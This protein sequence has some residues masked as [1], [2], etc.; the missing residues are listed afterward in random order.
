[1][2]AVDNDVWMLPSPHQAKRSCGKDGVGGETCTMPHTHTQ[3]ESKKMPERAGCGEKI[4][5]ESNMRLQE[6]TFHIHAFSIGS[7]IRRPVPYANTLWMK[8]DEQ[9]T[10]ARRR[11]VVDL[12][13]SPHGRWKVLSYACSGRYWFRATR[14]TRHQFHI[15][16]SQ[17][18]GKVGLAFLLVSLFAEAT[19]VRCQHLILPGMAS[20]Q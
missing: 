18:G 9:K 12:W 6:A 17:I 19:S 8:Q 14:T 16:R 15:S 3:T 13:M 2:P 4:P 7:K 20:K 1:M 5:R 10:T 11:R